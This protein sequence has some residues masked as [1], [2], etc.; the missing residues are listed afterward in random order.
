[1]MRFR[2]TVSPMRYVHVSVDSKDPDR[3]ADVRYEG[4]PVPISE[5]R[6]RLMRT[7]GMDGRLLEPKTT[8]LDL[9]AAMSK[10]MMK[11]YAPECL[12]GQDLLAKTKRSGK[13]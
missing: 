9:W 5:V 4:D 3:S 6:E 2:L 7:Q 12:E 10:P 13:P 8:P 1:M 11:P